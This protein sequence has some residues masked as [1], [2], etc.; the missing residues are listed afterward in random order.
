[1]S[2]FLSF[3]VFAFGGLLLL[4]V[5]LLFLQFFISPSGDRGGEHTV[6]PKS[7]LPAINLGTVAQFDQELDQM[8]DSG[9]LQAIASHVKAEFQPGRHLLIPSNIT[10]E[11]TQ[12]MIIIDREMRRCDTDGSA[13]TDLPPIVPR[14][15]TDAKM[16]ADVRLSTFL[17]V[18][19]KEPYYITIW[20]VPPL[21]AQP[22]GP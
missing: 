19:V 2:R 11:R 12:E 15:K 4:V 1:M 14:A 9:G 8:Y 18:H 17:H 16:E 10:T 22:H 13:M 7:D 21:P 6:P 20:W 5:G 3:L